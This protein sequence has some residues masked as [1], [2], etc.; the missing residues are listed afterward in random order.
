MKTSDSFLYRFNREE[1]QKETIMDGKYLVKYDSEDGRVHT[2][3]VNVGLDCPQIWETV[4]LPS[5][6]LYT[7][8]E[9][10]LIDKEN[11]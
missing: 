3:Y 9:R 1:I 5:A 7:E 8:C 10:H 11:N 4:D 6:E 2:I